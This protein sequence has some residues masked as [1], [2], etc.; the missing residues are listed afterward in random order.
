MQ[1]DRRP[2]TKQQRPSRHSSE[3]SRGRIRK[4]R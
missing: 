3:V 2:G 1:D 4:H